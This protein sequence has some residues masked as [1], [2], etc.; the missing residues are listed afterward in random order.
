MSRPTVR[1]GFALMALICL[2]ACGHSQSPGPSIAARPAGPTA[3]AA[4]VSPDPLVG[5]VFLGGGDLH[6][7]AAAVLHSKTRDLIVTAAHC[8]PGGDQATF[9]PGFTD[10]GGPAGVWTVDAVYLDPRWLSSQDP[11]ADFAIAR[12]HRDGAGSLEDAVGSGLALG[13]APTPGSVVTITAYQG[14]AGGAPIGCSAA[15]GTAAGGFPLVHCAG[16]GDGSSGGPWRSE[17][18]VVGLIGGLHGGGCDETLSYSPPFGDAVTQLLARAEA[19]GPADEPPETFADDCP[20][21]PTT[22]IG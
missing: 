6:D 5:A 8:L 1:G 9:V 19:G 12:V 11:V 17:S 22:G 13:H 16:F 20:V 10:G 15:T 7:C 18:S 21:G 4:P 3:T 14:G 2:A